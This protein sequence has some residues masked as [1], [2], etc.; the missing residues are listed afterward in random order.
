MQTVEKHHG[1]VNMQ[2]GL[3]LMPIILHPRSIGT[4]RLHSSSPHDPPVIDAQFL[5][6]DE[7][8]K[9]AISGNLHT[10]L[11]SVVHGPKR[12]ATAQMC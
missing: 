8:V 11:V 3:S 6:A 2:D 5:T 10:L 1:N 9:T 7:D 4:V 12:Y